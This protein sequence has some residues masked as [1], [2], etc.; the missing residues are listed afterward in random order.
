MKQ[1]KISLNDAI[2]IAQKAVPDGKVVDTDVE[3]VK[4]VVQYAIDID[5]DGV[6]TVFVDLQTG[7][8]IRTV[9][10]KDDTMKRRWGLSRIG[11][12][13]AGVEAV[14]SHGRRR[15]SHTSPPR[16]ERHDAAKHDVPLAPGIFTIKLI[17]SAAETRRTS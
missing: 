14:L 5:K 15:P 9:P 13:S 7:N 2:A 12:R 16:H 8:V 3:T 4:G 17:M 11:A 6:K 10:K 1:A